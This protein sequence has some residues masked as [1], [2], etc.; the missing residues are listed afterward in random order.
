MGVIYKITNTI[1][2]KFYIGRTASDG[3]KRWHDH[4]R[5]LERN[6]HHNKFLQQSWNKY[7]KEAFTFE[8]IDAADDLATLNK[9][10]IE[11]ITKT[12]AQVD[13]FNKHPGGAWARPFTE[14]HRRNLSKALTGRFMNEEHR[15][16]IS[17]SM[18]GNKHCVGRVCSEETRE[19]LRQKALKQ[20]EEG[21]GHTFRG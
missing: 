1:S 17:E 12:N 10:E 6:T 5:K 18:M 20:W 3:T 16:I 21:R 11:W 8:V 9:K 14:E 4:R 13:G 15:R 19:K 2:D 7:G